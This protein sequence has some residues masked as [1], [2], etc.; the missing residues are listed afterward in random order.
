MGASPAEVRDRLGALEAVLCPI[1]EQD[2]ARV[3]AVDYY[4]FRIVRC[5]TCQLLYLHPRPNFN[6]LVEN[7]YVEEYHQTLPAVAEMPDAIRRYLFSRQLEGI[8]RHVQGGSL[9]D[10]GCGQGGFLAF[11]QQR[12]WRVYGTEVS[13]ELVSALQRA[14]PQGTFF[15][16]RLDEVDFRGQ[17]FDAIYL[18]HVLEHTQNPVLLLKQAAEL[19]RESGVIYV[20]VPNVA[21]LDAR[22]KNLLSHLRLK[23]KRFR[24]L[25]ALHHLWFFTAETL[26]RATRAAK[27][28]A[29]RLETPVYF[30]RPVRAGLARVR[31]A[32]LEPLGLGNCVDAYLV[33]DAGS[34]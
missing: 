9:L 12:G 20:S 30:S 2:R 23:R 25:A 22:L 7:L 18:N 19:L 3:F 16:G 32:L 4:G 15:C 8:E 5:E 31:R 27:L 34:A 17:R 11:A 1:C 14:L 21:S 33:K 29:A 13:P 24:H 10:V 28:R 26:E 6:W